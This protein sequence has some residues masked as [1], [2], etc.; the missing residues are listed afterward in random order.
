MTTLMQW[1]VL[2]LI[3]FALVIGTA[4][5]VR[6]FDE[7]TRRD[8]PSRPYRS[9]GDMQQTITGP[10]AGE[11]RPTLAVTGGGRVHPDRTKGCRARCLA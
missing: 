5:I 7:R 8:A 9:N 10:E 2:F 3:A 1:P 4:V 6:A 11:G